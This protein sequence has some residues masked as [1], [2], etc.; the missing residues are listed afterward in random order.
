MSL[1]LKL[2]FAGG[3]ALALGLFGLVAC[4]G[5]GE[6]IIQTVV[7]EKEVQVA[8][9]TVIQTV[10]VEREVEIA[11]PIDREVVITA[12]PAAG[13]AVGDVEQFGTLKVAV[14]GVGT[15]VFYPQ[16]A[17]FPNNMTQYLFGIQE[18]LF[19][20]NNE[21][22]Q[23]PSLALSYELAGDLSEV[24]FTIR[25]G[26]HF[27]TDSK[28]LGEMTAE[29]VAWSFNNTGAD[30][31]ASR[32]SAAGEINSVFLPWEVK[33]A[34]KVSAPFKEYRGDWLTFNTV[35]TC[36][37]SGAVASKALFDEV[38]ADEM[39][40]TPHGTGPFIVTTWNA[41][42]KIEAR[43]NN[44]H[45]GHVPFVEN[46]VYLEVPEASV[47]SA[48]L[49]TGEVDIAPVPISDVPSLTEAGFEFNAGLRQF[50][51]HFINFAGNH[52]LDYMPENNEPVERE[53]LIDDEHPWIGD[54]DDPV[55]DESARKVRHA[56]GMA[57]DRD[58]INET[59]LAGYGGP[60]YGDTHLGLH[61]NHPEWKDKWVVP[62]DVPAAKKLLAEAGYPEG[63]EI[64]DFFCPVSINVNGEVCQAVAGMWSEL[65]GGKK[66][67][68]DT[69]A[70]TARRPTMVGRTIAV[71]W[72]TQWGPNRLAYQ[73][74]P[75]G[76][77]GSG[78]FPIPTGG[79]N[80]GNE[81]IEFWDFYQEMLP[82]ER[83][84]AENLATRERYFDWNYHMRFAVGVVEVPTLIGVNPDRVLQ[85]K[86][87][88]LRDINS[89]E[90]VIL[91]K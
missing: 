21:S 36:N 62:Y 32:H 38:G 67:Q 33:T 2:R 22:C 84:S 14:P 78:N 19:E 9:E 59:I 34:T 63:F 47:R 77:N 23:V 79:Y 50:L 45:W 28:D 87:Q 68:L 83:G 30:N 64:P 4:G 5:D 6:T 91:K 53:K 44:D 7:V 17:V 88:P 37:D 31:P 48:Q 71:P 10:V 73:G 69:S 40:I 20:W 58:L 85:W 75:G 60:I 25:K 82:Q 12:V 49:R 90:S 57:I 11:V 65:M 54:P 27:L 46:I 51:G 41:N 70:Y 55:R 1:R 35:S 52:R 8:G 15:P 16:E 26:V 43:A 42:E 74:E 66:V 29:D 80:Q 18:T 39:L 3:L 81:A 56:L 86:L 61:Q 76:V 24:T 72:M 13:A 89:F